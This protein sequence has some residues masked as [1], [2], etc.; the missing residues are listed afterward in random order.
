MK[1][2]EAQAFVRR[3]KDEVINQKDP[4]AASRFFA[5]DFSTLNPIPGRAPGLPG[6]KVALREFF[7]AFPDIHETVHEVVA[8][9]DS[10][11][12]ASSIRATH[13]GTFIGVPATG[14]RVEFNVFE[15][16]HLKGGKVA[17]AWVFFDGLA[18]LGQVGA[19]PG[20]GPALTK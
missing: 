18:Y 13:A 5:S 10:I 14:R 7:D 19:P 9:G 11:C 8:E 1:P 12:L 3:L 6:L 2:A 16:Y 15:I 20:G 17:S 4:E